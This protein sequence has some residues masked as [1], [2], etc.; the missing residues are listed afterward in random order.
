MQLC[1]ISLVLTTLACVGDS[2]D[3]LY[4]GKRFLKREADLFINHVSRVFPE[5]DPNVLSITIGALESFFKEVDEWNDPEKGFDIYALAHAIR[6]AQ[7][8]SELA[9]I[10]PS[11]NV[12]DLISPLSVELLSEVGVNLMSKE[13][14]LSEANRNKWGVVF[15]LACKFGLAPS[16]V[17]GLFVDADTNLQ[18]A[19]WDESSENS[20][21]RIR[22]QLGLAPLAVLNPSLSRLIY[23]LRKKA[24]QPGDLL[25]HAD[26]ALQRKTFLYL[27]YRWV[28][29]WVHETVVRMMNCISD[30]VETLPYIRKRENDLLSTLSGAFNALLNALTS[31]SPVPDSAFEQLTVQ[32]ESTIVEAFRNEAKKDSLKLLRDRVKAR[33]ENSFD[34]K[35]YIIPQILLY[36]DRAS[37]LV[38][39]RQ[40][41]YSWFGLLVSCHRRQATASYRKIHGLVEA[42]VGASLS[43]LDKREENA[44]HLVG[45]GGVLRVTTETLDKVEGS[46]SLQNLVLQTT[47]EFYRR[48]KIFIL[49]EMVQGWWSPERVKAIRIIMKSFLI[50]G[51]R[52]WNK[53]L[54]SDKNFV[55]HFTQASQEQVDKA[56]KFLTRQALWR[57]HMYRLD[58]FTEVPLFSPADWLQ[59]YLAP[60][61]FRSRYALWELT[62]QTYRDP[63]SSILG[64]LSWDL[65]NKISSY[66]PVDSNHPASESADLAHEISSA[67]E[68]IWSPRRFQRGYWVNSF[69][70]ISDTLLSLPRLIMQV[71]AELGIID[72]DKSFSTREILLGSARSLNRVFTVALTRDNVGTRNI[73]SIQNFAIEIRKILEYLRS[74]RIPNMLWRWFGIQRIGK[75][76]LEID[77]VGRNIMEGL[78]TY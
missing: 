32:L 76:R 53:L 41:H 30:V 36:I 11:R 20:M 2:S 19:S 7:F 12:R 59:L 5:E 48:F 28:G 70:S 34:S 10:F 18:G 27:R 46:D 8:D 23:V 51:N 17:L 49:T 75:L 43:I 16:E 42:V 47:F 60:T 39:R 71:E 57:M 52:E 15:S 26:F 38:N 63:L 66:L 37:M 73:S 72:R 29:I 62:V 1:G 55:S 3:V 21:N 4:S 77:R 44:F 9:S 35:V 33:E 13:G 74:P 24:D 68:E 31:A 45:L 40:H 6:N 54:S 14:I 22:W 65:Q 64:F 69:R 67:Y 50:F 25:V 58:K 78:N 61:I 56:V